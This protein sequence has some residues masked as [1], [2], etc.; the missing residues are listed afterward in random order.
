MARRSAAGFRRRCPAMG[1]VSHRVLAGCGLVRLTAD[2]GFSRVAGDTRVRVVVD[3]RIAGDNDRLRAEVGRDD[4]LALAGAAATASGAPRLLCAT[5]ARVAGKACRVGCGPRSGRRACE[6]IRGRNRA[7]AL[8]AFRGENRQ[9]AA[10]HD[11][12]GVS[13]AAIRLRFPCRPIRGRHRAS[14]LPAFRGENRQDGAARGQRGANGAAVRLRFPCRPVCG[15]HREFVLRVLRV[16]NRA[17]GAA[18]G[19]RGV[20]IAAIPLALPLPALRRNR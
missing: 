4:A 10:A 17:H 5:S 20:S 8:L 1:C 16:E 19:Y 12:R 9:V 15:R 7:S 3:T 6:L 18:Y 2:R 14:A 13:R 11:R